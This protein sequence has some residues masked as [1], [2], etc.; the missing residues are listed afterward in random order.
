MK[1]RRAPTAGGGHTKQRLIQTVPFL[2]AAHR[3]RFGGVR[4]LPARARLL[5]SLPATAETA[6]FVYFQGDS[7]RRRAPGG[8][9]M[10]RHGVSIDDQRTR[11]ARC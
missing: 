1:S 10:G 2:N 5:R 8:D 3:D 4:T 6:T 7:W 9:V 11:C